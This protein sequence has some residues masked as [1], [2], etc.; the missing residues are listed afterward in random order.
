MS[1]CYH[2][3]CVY[4]TICYPADW[5]DALVRLWKKAQQR[6]GPLTHGEVRD[7]LD[8]AAPSCGLQVTSVCD[9]AM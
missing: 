2:V 7:Q 5:D 9:A 3:S 8:P 1:S 4:Y 6:V